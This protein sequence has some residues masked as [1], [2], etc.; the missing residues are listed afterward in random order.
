MNSEF[1]TKNIFRLAW[2][3]IISQST[4]LTVGI[5][6][7]LFIGQLGTAAIAAIAISNAFINTFYQFMEGI[8]TGTTVLTARNFGAEDKT[9]ISKVLNLSMIFSLIIGI[10]II[11]VA[12]IIS[13]LVYAIAQ[14]PEALSAGGD[15]YLYIRLLETPFFLLFLAI[16]GFFRGLENTFIPLMGSIFI[17]FANIILAYSFIYGKFGVPALGVEGAAW[18]TLMANTIGTI[19]MFV[20]LYKSKLTKTYLKLIFKFKQLKK[21]YLKISL[22]IGIFMG[23]TSLAFL[24]FMFLFSRLG[25]QTIAA[26]QITFQVFL[27]SY[28]PPHG[29]LVATTIII[30]KL[31]GEKRKDL[32]LPATLKII[33]ICFIFMGIISL[34]LFFFSYKIALLFSPMDT[35]VAELASKT[36]KL[37]SM[38]ELIATFYLIVMGALT[39]AKD[40]RFLVYVSFISSYLVFLPTSYFLG[41]TLK[42]GI[43]GGYLG[44]IVWA[45]FDGLV[46][47]W[48]FFIQRKWAK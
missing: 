37:I 12:P 3:T 11:L 26:H 44:F 6:D 10:I 42:L 32:V 41:I 9:T 17:F 1:S 30:G 36:I 21:E 33:F 27:I 28:L 38:E 8:R 15:K 2:P 48:R 35:I 29:F 31:F 23:L 39:A 47:T 45:L 5:I 7:L 19:A 34:L 43:F 18:A 16:S 20:F 24:I 14:S 40:T 13:N 46:L 4:I 25:P 22:D